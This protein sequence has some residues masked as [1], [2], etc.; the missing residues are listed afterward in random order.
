M[1]SGSRD[2]IARG[3][4]WTSFLSLSLLPAPSAAQSS[5]LSNL[6]RGFGGGFSTVETPVSVSTGAASG[7]TTFTDGVLTAPA[8]TVLAG[9]S[10]PGAA[11][12]QSSLPTGASGGAG[13]TAPA[14]RAAAAR[15]RAE[16]GASSSL[17]SSALNVVLSGSSSNPE[18]Q[19]ALVLNGKVNLDGGQP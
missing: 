19:G 14:A 2:L 11:T 16:A 8:G 6:S 15:V 12:A 7:G 1:S 3:V 5:S 9:L 4:L 17:G 18:P 13:E 10:A